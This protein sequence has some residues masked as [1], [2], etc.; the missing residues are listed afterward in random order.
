[1]LLAFECHAHG[2]L[3]RNLANTNQIKE[4]AKIARDLPGEKRILIMKM[5]TQHITFNRP[6]K[7]LP[8]RF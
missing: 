2:L 7:A 4:K 5:R 3:L 1:M 6:I 8:V